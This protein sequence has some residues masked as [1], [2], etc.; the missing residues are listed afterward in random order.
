MSILRRTSAE[1]A[2]HK[3]A[4]VVCYACGVP[5]YRLVANIWMSEATSNTGWKYAPVSMADLQMIIDR[6]DLDPGIRAAIKFWTLEQQKA[7][8][9]SIP[10]LRNG[11]LPPC[12]S[13]K[14]Q[15]ARA[16][17]PGM[18]PDDKA[19][20]LDRSYVVSLATIEPE[21]KA[22][23]LTMAGQLQKAPTTRH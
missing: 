5:L 3:G 14:G 2:Y 6:R 20:F 17:R 11:E 4:I 18:T 19:R 8:C 16:D 13:C 7:H 9:D 23:P 10:T 1:V 12:P 22:R 21:G 15:F